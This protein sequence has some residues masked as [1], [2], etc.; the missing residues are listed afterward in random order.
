MATHQHLTRGNAADQVTPDDVENLRDARTHLRV[1]SPVRHV[2][3]DLLLALCSS[4]YTGHDV[5]V[6]IG[7]ASAAS[8]SSATLPA[9]TDPKG[10]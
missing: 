2:L 7:A 6:D 8:S 3:D 10:S 1:D 5:I 9:T 4:G